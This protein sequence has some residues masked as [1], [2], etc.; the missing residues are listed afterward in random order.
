M[1]EGKIFLFK[2]N[3]RAGR[4]VEKFF[5]SGG[6][7]NYYTAPPRQRTVDL[8]LKIDM[9]PF[10]VMSDMAAALIIS[11][12]LLPLIVLLSRPCLYRFLSLTALPVSKQNYYTLGGNTMLFLSCRG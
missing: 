9:T 6:F 1:S 7:V 12:T 3:R 11:R 10:F 5:R 4:K 2:L 8:V